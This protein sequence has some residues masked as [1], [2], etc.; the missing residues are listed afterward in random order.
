MYRNAIFYFEL[1]VFELELSGDH[2][3]HL[4]VR[5]YGISGAIG[6]RQY[7]SPCPRLV[8]AVVGPFLGPVLEVVG[9][10]EAGPILVKRPPRLCHF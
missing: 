3:G 2:L 6:A 4:G 1:G 7:G 9:G 8:V 5:M 10:E